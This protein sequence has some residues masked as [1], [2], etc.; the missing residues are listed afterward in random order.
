MLTGFIRNTKLK[1]ILFFLYLMKI[2]VWIFS[3]IVRIS[4]VYLRNIGLYIKCLGKVV[5]KDI[6]RFLVVFWVILITFSVSF[7]MAMRAENGTVTGR[8]LNNK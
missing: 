4:L 3:R 1:N 5:Y 2:L 6:P 7:Y 8:V